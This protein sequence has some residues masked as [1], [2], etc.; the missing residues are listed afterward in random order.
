MPAWVLE[1]V[2]LALAVVVARARPALG[3]RW[4]TA[5]EQRLGA[6]ARRRRLAV[7]AV[8]A[9]ALGLRLTLL[10]LTPVPEPNVHDEF[11]HL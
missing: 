10:P 9:T 8:G 2:L 6:L 1:V 3:S 5:A 4:M 11:S 7:L